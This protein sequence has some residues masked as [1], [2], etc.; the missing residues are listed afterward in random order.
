MS[1]RRPLGASGREAVGHGRGRPGAV[2]EDGAVSRGEGERDRRAGRAWL[3][4]ALALVVPVLVTAVRVVRSGWVPAIDDAT[5][6]TRAYDVWSDHPPLVGQFSLATTEVAQAAHSPGP[7]LYWL[8]SPAARSGW[9][10]AIPL[11]M[12]LVNAALLVAC[13]GLA[14]RR[15]GTATAVAATIGLAFLVR[16]FGPVTMVEIWNPW[17]ALIPFTAL[18]FVAWSVADGDRALLPVAVLLATFTM[19]THLAYLFPS[20]AALTVAVLAGWVERRDGGGRLGIRRRRGSWPPLLAAVV[21]GLVGWAVPLYEQVTRHPG[22]LTLLVRSNRDSGARGGLDAARSS[23]WRTI[24]VPPKWLRSDANPA[25]EILKGLVAP[26]GRAT[27]GT[28]AVLGILISATVLL[29]RRRDGSIVRLAALAWSL[30]A[31]VVVVAAIIPLRNALVAGYTFRW[32]AV[33]SLVAWWV[34]AAAV[35]RHLVPADRRTAMA[36]AAAR[37]PW[38]PLAVAG[39]VLVAG[40]LVPTPDSTA[41]SYR[42]AHDLGDL[43]VGATEPG[44]T[45]LVAQPGHFDLAFTPAI[46]WRLRT[47]GRNVV[48]LHPHDKAFG[49]TYA[50]RGDRR[51]DGLLRLDDPGAPVPSGARVVGSVDIVDG[52]DLPPSMRLSILPDTSPTGRC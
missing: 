11:T 45:Y 20:V 25:S 21:V 29:V 44:G 23:L 39:L 10:P 48:L 33:A 49:S 31:A 51:C 18:V 13:V 16:A 14:Q 1:A 52:P 30:L 32:F 35:A 50:V 27:V 47:S 8:V 7:M 5:I 38:W 19:Q 37:R 46:A 34:V 22:N 6:S 42:P 17:A 15:G 3:V 36:D 9:W 2:R 28:L 43:V 4:L 26:S 12:A 40:L 41:W 24:G